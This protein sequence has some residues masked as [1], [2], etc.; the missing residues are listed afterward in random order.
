MIKNVRGNEKGMVLLVVVAIV[1]AMTTLVVT[2]LSH[3]L[4]KA[5]T[6][7]K[8]EEELRAEYMAKGAMWK[9]IMANGTAVAYTE[10]ASGMIYDIS[11]VTGGTN[12][13]SQVLWKTGQY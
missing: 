6:L 4:T 13:N 5:S 9:S 12:V 7:S 11:V 10:N 8:T 1:L 3:S 2:I